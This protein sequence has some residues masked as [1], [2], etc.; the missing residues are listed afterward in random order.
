MRFDCAPYNGLI[1]FAHLFDLLHCTGK[2][3]ALAKLRLESPSKRIDGVEGEQHVRAFENNCILSSGLLEYLWREKNKDYVE[4]KTKEFLLKVMYE[5]AL[6]CPVVKAPLSKNP[7]NFREI[8]SFIVPS[9]IHKKKTPK[10][11]RETDKVYTFF[12]DFSSFYPI[13]VFE[14]LVCEAVGIAAS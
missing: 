7:L 3:G 10:D 5:A 12:F 14:M 1:H 11:P 2:N 6:I 4:E 9:C 13:G 8:K